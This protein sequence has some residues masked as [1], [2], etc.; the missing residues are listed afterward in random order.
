[1]AARPCWAAAGIGA[2]SMRVRDGYRAAARAKGGEGERGRGT[3]G[4]TTKPGRAQARTADG[5]LRSRAGEGEEDG[6]PESRVTR[7]RT[8][9]SPRCSAVD[10]DGESRGR[11]TMA[12]WSRSLKWEGLRWGGELGFGLYRGGEVGLGGNRPRRSRS[13]RW[14]SSVVTGA[15][16]EAMVA[17]REKAKRGRGKGALLLAVFGRAEGGESAWEREALPPRLGHMRAAAAEWAR[18]AARRRR[19]RADGNRGRS[20]T[21]AGARTGTSEGGGGLNRRGASGKRRERERENRVR[22]RGREESERSLSSAAHTRRTY[23]GRRG[24]G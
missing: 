12:R 3:E 13:G 21:M 18:A 14:R 19:A 17:G 20:A 7:P 4:G 23:E 11:A 8:H 24:N 15:A 6:R 1:M 22:K 10:S 5:P 2:A 16:E 9:R